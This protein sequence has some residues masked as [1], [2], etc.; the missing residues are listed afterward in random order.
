[1]RSTLT[2]FL[3]NGGE[4]FMKQKQMRLYGVIAAVFA[5]IAIVVT[6]AV[7]MN[8][9][10]WLIGLRLADPTIF[11]VTGRMNP[12]LI[13]ERIRRQQWRQN[14]FGPWIA[15]EFVKIAK[16]TVA[17]T[18][19]GSDMPK[20]TGAPIEVHDAFITRGKT[21]MDIPVMMRLT[22]RPVFGDKTLKGKGEGARVLYRSVQINLT[23]KAYKPPQGIS[24][25]IA[26]P[27]L[28]GELWKAEEHLTTFLNDFHPGNFIL[29]LL[30]GASLD[31]V[32]PTAEG[33]R[34]MNYVSHPNF[35]VAGNGP[36]SYVAG[37]PGTVGYEASVEAALS[38]L[39]DVATD[40]MSV[41][42]VK[43]LTKEAA[44]RRIAPISVNG[45]FKFYAMW[46]SDSQW[47]QLQNDAEF[48][49]WMKRLPDTLK[50]SPLA[51][52]AEA[53]IDGCAIY[54][55]QNLFGAR[56]NATDPSVPAGTVEYGPAPTAEE[57]ALGFKVGNWIENRDTSNIKCG[58]IIGQN[59]L[60]VGVGVP[61]LG[62]Q[63][64]P[65]IKMSEEIDDHGMIVEIGMAMVQSVVR[66]DQYDHDAMVSGNTAGD[67]QENTGSLVFATYSP[68]ALAYS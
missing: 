53:W 23:R 41:G 51:T 21:E 4:W 8:E 52:G 10:S 61:L 37:K 60:S 59:A 47:L 50:T 34:A 56:I 44:R 66:T 7:V 17:V 11:S 25:Q 16:D 42:L 26:L 49:D 63:K 46:I 15:P 3:F 45:R 18:T 36:V 62:N 32:A 48:K 57:R 5:V 38:G 35:I 19:P 55:D 67:F 29:S 1:V 68:D 64:G 43:K 40:Y 58:F 28:E 20:F 24:A 54:V 22:K 39:S 13:A 14:I 33:G 31:L 6:A 65:K 30:A 2:V 12:R 9:P 27:Y